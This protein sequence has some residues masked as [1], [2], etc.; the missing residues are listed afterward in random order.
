MKP[1]TFLTSVLVCIFL[2]MAFIF[3]KDF[4]PMWMEHRRSMKQSS[5]YEARKHPKSE[6]RVM[7]EEERAELDDFL[8]PYRFPEAINL[9]EHE[10]ALA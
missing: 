8:T 9:D 4:C 3:F 2:Y 5:Q 10:K 7:T 1:E 6:W